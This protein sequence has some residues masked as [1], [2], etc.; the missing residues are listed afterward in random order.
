MIQVHASAHST[1]P[2]GNQ[3][4]LFSRLLSPRL[5]KRLAEGVSDDFCQTRVRL[6][7]AL[8][9]VADQFIRQINGSSHKLKH[10][11]FRR[12][13][14]DWRLISFDRRRKNKKAEAAKLLR[15]FFG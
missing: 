2:I 15:P 5:G 1:S 4:E 13:L 12:F 7:S 6:Q 8:L 11:P 3:F 14:Q 9:G 10:P